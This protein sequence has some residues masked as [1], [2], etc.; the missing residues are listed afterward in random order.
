MNICSPLVSHLQILPRLLNE[1]PKHAKH[2][3]LSSILSSRND[4]SSYPPLCASATASF[5]VLS[6][7]INAVMSTL[8]AEAKTRSRRGTEGRLIHANAKRLQACEC[9]KLNL[10]AALHLERLRLHDSSS[11]SSSSSSG[12]GRDADGG[13]V[14]ATPEGRGG[15]DRADAVVDGGGDVTSRLLRGGIRKLEDELSIV[16]DKINDV[17]EEMRCVAADVDDE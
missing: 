5:S 4:V 14:A 17:L 12:G 13:G 15:G 8:L 16:V 9:E 3:G 7:T 10:T 2:R 1:S 6:D 11:S